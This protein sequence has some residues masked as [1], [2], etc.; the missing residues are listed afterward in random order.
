MNV[1]NVVISF[2]EDRI[3]RIP[4]PE[5]TRELVANTQKHHVNHLLEEQSAFILTKLLMSGVDISNEQ[6]QKNFVLVM[7]CLRA[8]IYETLQITHPLQNPMREML[9]MIEDILLLKDDD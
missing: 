8:S 1:A 7:E 4:I 9:E 3:V 5:S 6:F 2:P